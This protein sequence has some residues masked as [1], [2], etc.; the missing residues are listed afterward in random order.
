MVAFAPSAPGAPR[1]LTL[2]THVVARSVAGALS[3]T[4]AAAALLAFAPPSFDFGTRP[5]GSSTD[6]VFTITNTGGF[7]ASAIV[8][9]SLG[10][11][12]SYKAGAFPGTGGTCSTTLAASATCTIVVTFAPTVPGSV[13]ATLSLGY[14]DGAGAKTSPPASWA[15]RHARR[16]GLHRR[17]HLRLRHA[18]RG[19]RPSTR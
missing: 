11:G 2:A 6:E 15:G 1:A 13:S 7:L 18:P 9:G 5:D 3:G 12:F 8:P 16:A 10:S 17:A 14:N 19:R 4:G